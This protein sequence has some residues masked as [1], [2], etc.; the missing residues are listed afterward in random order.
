MRPEETTDKRTLKTGKVFLAVMSIVL[1]MSV[2]LFFGWNESEVEAS[3]IQVQTTSNSVTVSGH[4]NNSS[5]EPIANVRVDIYVQSS[6]LDKKT[7]KQV[8]CMGPAGKG[9]TDSKGQYGANQDRPTTGLMKVEWVRKSTTNP[10]LVKTFN[11][12]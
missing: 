7:N 4:V 11:I 10:V 1:C 6:V 12:N 3:G 2:L 8:L 5:N 9:M